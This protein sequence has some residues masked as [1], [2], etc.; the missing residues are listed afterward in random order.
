MKYPINS[1]FHAFNSVFFVIKRD[2][3][4]GGLL[5]FFDEA[6]DAGSGLSMCEI[7][8]KQQ[9]MITVVECGVAS[10]FSTRHILNDESVKNVIIV[11]AALLEKLGEKRAG[12]FLHQLSLASAFSD[13]KKITPTLAAMDD[14]DVRLVDNVLATAYTPTGVSSYLRSLTLALHRHY[15]QQG[16]FKAIYMSAKFDASP[17]MDR[18]YSYL[19]NL[20][21][22]R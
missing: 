17:K 18:R 22:R 20:E 2:V 14:S 21:R 4:P 6:V 15:K 13:V 19:K 16:F 9:F 12:M 1:F 5:D 8:D 3:A 7:S 10:V 11:S